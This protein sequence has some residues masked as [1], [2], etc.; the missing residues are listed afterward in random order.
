MPRRSTSE[1]SAAVLRLPGIGLAGPACAFIVACGLGSLLSLRML[2]DVLGVPTLLDD[3]TL[4]NTW[5]QMMT[6]TLVDP[7]PK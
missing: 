1:R 4:V 2:R 5:V 6:T 7:A 3:E